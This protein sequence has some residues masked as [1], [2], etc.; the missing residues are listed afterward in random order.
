VFRLL[1]RL[2]VDGLLGFAC[3]GLYGLVFGGFG[4]LLHGEAWKLISIAIGFGGWGFAVGALVGTCGAL[5]HAD[6]EAGSSGAPPDRMQP[7]QP[8]IEAVG[9]FVVPHRRHSGTASA[10][11]PDRTRSQTVG[12]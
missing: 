1:R 12:T 3:G 11:Q 7:K 10:A 5:F 9:H 8:S 2:T 4:A 6:G